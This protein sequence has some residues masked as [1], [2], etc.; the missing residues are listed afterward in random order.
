MSVKQPDR[1]GLRKSK[2]MRKI[3]SIADIAS[4]PGFPP[5]H[6]LL[7]LERRVKILPLMDGREQWPR[8]ED[9]QN[10]EVSIPHHMHAL[11]DRNKACTKR[12]ML[13]PFDMRKASFRPYIPDDSI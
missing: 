10:N 6:V 7:I 3:D 9:W 4:V 8:T 11:Q 2:L 1:H 13:A 5:F 12:V